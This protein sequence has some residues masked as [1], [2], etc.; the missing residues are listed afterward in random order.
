MCR[1]R[2]RLSRKSRS[3]IGTAA[4]SCAIVCALNISL[5]C[6]DAP[7]PS[8]LRLVDRHTLTRRF[9]RQALPA[10]PAKLQVG[11]SIDNY[12]AADF[13]SAKA[14]THCCARHKER[15]TL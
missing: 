7:A 6:Q 11:K 2:S 8:R 10:V 1:G 14:L 5:N 13:L 9:T 15:V 4:P 3:N 12:I